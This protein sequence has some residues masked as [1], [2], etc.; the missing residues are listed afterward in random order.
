[1][2]YLQVTDHLPCVAFF[3]VRQIFKTR[4]LNVTR[5]CP[6]LPDP[7]HPGLPTNLRR[8]SYQNGSDILG[9]AAQQ[10]TFGSLPY[11]RAR[12]APEA[13]HPRRLS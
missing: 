9:T 1:M 2:D 5:E 4:P 6:E 13:S 12:A 10:H 8:P 3:N 7:S 11:Q